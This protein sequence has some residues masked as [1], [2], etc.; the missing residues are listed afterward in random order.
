MKTSTIDHCY[1]F[2]SAAVSVATNYK[3]NDA[4]DTFPGS[5]TSTWNGLRARME[6][7][8]P[9]LSAILFSDMYFKGKGVLL[10]ANGGCQAVSNTNYEPYLNNFLINGG[11][12]K[13]YTYTGVNLNEVNS[14]SF[15]NKVNSAI[16]LNR[17]AVAGARDP[18]FTG[19]SFYARAAAD[20]F[21]APT[22]NGVTSLRFFHNPTQKEASEA[23]NYAAKAHREGTAPSFPQLAV[24]T[25][26]PATK[27][28]VSSDTRLDG[29]PQYNC[30]LDNS[31]RTV[32][33]DQAV[34]NTES[35]Q[36]ETG[37][38]VRLEFD[39]G[40]L[41]ASLELSVKQSWGRTWSATSRVATQDTMT[42]R[43]EY[44]GW[45]TLRPSLERYTVTTGV[46]YPDGGPRLNVQYQM[47]FAIPSTEMTTQAVGLV[48]QPMTAAERTSMC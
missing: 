40:D 43:P 44:K 22:T 1:R 8:N 29:G 17:C 12:Q 7:A 36:T 35:F 24:C 33:L 18:N 21:G 34:T 6:Q 3:V 16:G 26:N 45:V 41:K 23:C 27:Q 13:L 39:F 20:N 14:G 19:G 38:T 37:Q 28:V 11:R 15:D 46:D 9:E 30:T 32:W 47:D 48:T 2:F 25:Y 31:T 42:I 10:V 4:P 5:G